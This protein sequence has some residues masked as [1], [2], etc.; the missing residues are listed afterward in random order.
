MKDCEQILL[1]AWISGDN[2]E[3]IKEFDHFTYFPELFEAIRKMRP[4]DINILTVSKTARI[5]LSELAK[6]TSEYMPVMYDPY[7]R[8]KKEEKIK[9]MLLDLAKDPNSITQESVEAVYKEFDTLHAVRVKEP[10]DLCES[11]KNELEKRKTV[12]PLKYGLPTLDFITGGIRRQEL[13]TI[14]ARPS[15]GKTAISLQIAFNL[16]LKKHK[17]LFFPLEMAPFQLMER[18]ACRETNIKHEKLKNP[19]KMDEKDKEM[20]KNFF[21]IYGP[22]VNPYLYI[23]DG[24]S[25]LAEIKRYI[26]HYKPEVVFID[27]LTQL[28]EN[29]KFNTIREQ[30]SYMT[31][32]LKAFTMSMD[33]PIILLCQISRS[34]ENKAPTFTDLKESGSIEETSDNIIALHQTDEAIGDCT[35]TDLIILKQRNGK[36]DVKIPCMYRNEKF[37]FQEV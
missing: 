12:E 16:A 34:G 32:N 25:R 37:I 17:V 36:R 29:K 19:S 1:S 27:Q 7:Y 2:K 6:F 10:T 28:D 31:Q 23:I 35:P 11:Y 14:A 18:I 30:F 9:A 8:T 22:V 13:T 26:E 21:E 5:K 20:L 3:H 24:V 33:I 4:K 15:V